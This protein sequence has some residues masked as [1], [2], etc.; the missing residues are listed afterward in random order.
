MFLNSSV[1]TKRNR[2][3]KELELQLPFFYY[4]VAFLCKNNKLNNIYI[5]I[6]TNKLKTRGEEKEDIASNKQTKTC[7]Y[8]MD[9]IDIAQKTWKCKIFISQSHGF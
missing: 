8:V 4:R 3:N 5:A 1:N 2:S 7:A 9:D 6:A